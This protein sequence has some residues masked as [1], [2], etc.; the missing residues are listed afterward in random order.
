M[1]M[2]VDFGDCVKFLEYRVLLDFESMAAR[3][4]VSARLPWETLQQQHITEC[5]DSP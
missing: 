4:K 1:F 5:T 3:L 2:K